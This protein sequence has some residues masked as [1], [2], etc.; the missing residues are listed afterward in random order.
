MQLPLSMAQS[1]LL[2]HFLYGRPAVRIYRRTLTAK[3]V[4]VKT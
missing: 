1:A 2:G 4:E 3:M